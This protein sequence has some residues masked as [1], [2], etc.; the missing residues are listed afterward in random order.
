MAEPWT[1]KPGPTLDA[2]RPVVGDR[3]IDELYR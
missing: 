1:P 2:Y 3:T